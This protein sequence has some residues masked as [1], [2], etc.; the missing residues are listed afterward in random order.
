MSLRPSAEAWPLSGPCSAGSSWLCPRP[1]GEGHRWLSTTF[2][3]EAMAPF[4]ARTASARPLLKPQVPGTNLVRDPFHSYSQSSSRVM[5]PPFLLEK[6][7][8]GWRPRCGGPTG[9]NGEPGPGQ[10]VRAFAVLQG[11]QMAAGPQIAAPTCRR[12]PLL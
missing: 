9:P 8:L 12:R 7:C 11:V 3:G 4:P 2:T 10:E 5:L 1:L 6:M